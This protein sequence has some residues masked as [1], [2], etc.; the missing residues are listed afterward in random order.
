MISHCV[1]S[2]CSLF[3]LNWEPL[4]SF[5]TAVATLGLV[6]VGYFQLRKLIETNKNANAISQEK[7]LYKLK[8]DFFTKDARDLLILIEEEA[9]F[10]N[11]DEKGVGYFKIAI[12]DGT[13]EVLRD[14]LN[15]NRKYYTTHEI[16]DF[17]LSP[18]EDVGLLL[19]KELIDV[20]DVTQNFEYY[21]N[22][23]FSSSEIKAYIKWARDQAKDND[24]Y[25]KAEWAYHVVEAYD[26]SAKKRKV[27]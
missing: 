7:F 19:E 8:G 20:H 9:L 23:I 2:C 6:W 18:L 3:S 13:K 1:L 16:D 5:L 25:S 14:S 27:N 10:F 24:I 15:I 21:L 22:A 17:L 12:E 4:W 26:K 11:G